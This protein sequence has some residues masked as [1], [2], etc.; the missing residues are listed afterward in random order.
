MNARKL[1]K[2]SL[3]LLFLSSTFT[4]AQE[5]VPGR[6]V[7]LFD[8][9]SKMLPNNVLSLNSDQI[10]YLDDD[11]FEAFKSINGMRLDRLFWPSGSNTLKDADTGY[12]TLHYD[13]KIS[14]D[15]AVSALR[16]IS[17]SSILAVSPVT[18]YSLYDYD[19][20]DPN[21]VNGDQWGFEQTGTYNDIDVNA[22][23]GWDYAKGDLDQLIAIIDT[24]IR[25]THEEFD[26]TN[27]FQDC[28]NCM[29]ASPTTYGWDTDIAG[30]EENEYNG[31][32]TFVAGIAAGLTGNDKGGVGVLGGDYQSTYGS[33]ISVLRAG[34][35]GIPDDYLARALV[36]AVDVNA[37]VVNFSGGNDDGSA[38]VVIRRLITLYEAGIPLVAAAG[39]KNLTH[40]GYPAKYAH[41]IAVGA[42]DSTGDRW[43]VDSTHGSNRG[44]LLDVVAP[45]E[46][47]APRAEGNTE[48]FTPNGTSSAAPFV[49]G[50]TGMILEINPSASMA[51]LQ[52]I[53]R[54]SGDDYPSHTDDFGFGLVRFDVAMD[55]AD[56][57][58]SWE[59]TGV[60]SYSNAELYDTTFTFRVAQENVWDIPIGEPGGYDCTFRRIPVK[61]EFETSRAANGPVA[62]WVEPSNTTGVLGLVHLLDEN[63]FDDFATPDP[64]TFQSESNGR[65]SGEILTYVYK[66]VKTSTQQNLGY[67]PCDP[68][69]VDVTYTYRGRLY[70][71]TPTFIT[72]YYEEPQ[73]GFPFIYLKW[74][75]N[76]AEELVTKYRLERSDEGG[77]YYKIGD[78]GYT[79]GGSYVEY[80]DDKLKD[81]EYLIN[82]NYFYLLTTIRITGYLD[83][84]LRSIFACSTL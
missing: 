28:W 56:G 44:P 5:Y 16:S 8:I 81:V 30:W 32:G 66:V 40:I 62:V 6:I 38:E 58:V 19:P 77:E 83:S 12:W 26:A 13:P 55:V 53:I 43:Y 54:A 68:G 59:K 48:Y 10:S 64:S 1:L 21:Y 70:A 45:T 27:K 7:I 31:H 33:A 9:E 15:Y 57:T 72:Y 24:G 36:K 34:Q 39:N 3:L 79:P 75:K 22:P 49:T 14:S 29:P 78:L 63:G 11:L 82:D 52:G 18:N 84:S 50:L 74:T 65:V 42:I 73:F 71:A 51:E 17:S 23:E 47:M 76:P 20:D 25:S 80:T 37:D 35:T 41:V 46:V 61:L 69:D 67:Y 60:A 2:L 4:A